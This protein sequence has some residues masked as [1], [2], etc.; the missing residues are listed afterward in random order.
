MQYWD[1]IIFARARKVIEEAIMRF[2]DDQA[3]ALMNRVTKVQQILQLKSFHEIMDSIRAMA[4]T[5]T[6]EMVVEIKL[7]V[8]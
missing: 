2:Q 4:S 1:K 6:K 8:N 3:T 7:T 5:T